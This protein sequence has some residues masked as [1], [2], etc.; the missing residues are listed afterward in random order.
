MKKLPSS[1]NVINAVTTQN[2]ITTVPIWTA[3]VFSCAAT[4]V[5]KS[6]QD[7]ARKSVYKPREYVPIT[8]KTPISLS[9][10]GIRI[11]QKKA[12]ISIEY[13][14]YKFYSEGIRRIRSRNKES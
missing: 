9:A 14:K 6:F 3:I 4:H 13:F 1:V 10:S 7:A 11:F 12:K 2:L 5:S 8:N